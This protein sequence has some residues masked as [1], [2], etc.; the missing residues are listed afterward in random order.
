MIDDRLW[1][2]RMWYNVPLELKDDMRSINIEGPLIFTDIRDVEGNE[3]LS[4]STGFPVAFRADD[5][6]LYVHNGYI[7]GLGPVD[8][9]K[10]LE[11]DISVVGDSKKEV[12]LY[13]GRK[14]Y[15]DKGFYRDA[16][17]GE[18]L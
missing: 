12:F 13:K 1:G 14:V 4:T 10:G 6:T 8:F 17:T 16:E 5:S 3:D 15:L 11:E 9:L 7:D 18:V 2:Q